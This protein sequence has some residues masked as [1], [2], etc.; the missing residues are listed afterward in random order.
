MRILELEVR[1]GNV[2]QGRVRHVED[3]D[4]DTLA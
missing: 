4:P 1:L 2:I 3:S